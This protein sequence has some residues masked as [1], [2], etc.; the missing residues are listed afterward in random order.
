MDACPGNNVDIQDLDLDAQDLIYSTYPLVDHRAEVAGWVAEQPCRWSLHALCHEFES[1]LANEVHLYRLILYKLTRAHRCCSMLE[2]PYDNSRGMCV[3]S[4]EAHYFS[5]TNGLEYGTARRMRSKSEYTNLSARR[6]LEEVVQ[7]IHDVGKTVPE[8]AGQGRQDIY[9]RPVEF[10]QRH[11]LVLHNTT[12]AFLHRP[13]PDQGER[14]SNA[15]PTR[16]DRIQAPHHHLCG[17][18]VH[19]RLAV[20]YVMLYLW[21]EGIGQ[22]KSSGPIHL[23]IG[24]E[25][26]RRPQR[27]CET[28]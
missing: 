17:A 1:M 24:R 22:T 28:R 21:S 3:T 26:I 11:K 4:L 7:E 23:S 6:C 2:V 27:V 9:P 10:L 5:Y 13:C 15:L 25:Y 20:Q 16:L 12:S 18:A 19:N 8:D 14:D